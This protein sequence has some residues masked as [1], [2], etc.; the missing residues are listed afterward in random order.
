MATP[1]NCFI[2]NEYVPRQAEIRL[3]PKFECFR[4]SNEIQPVMFRSSQSKSHF[5]RFVDYFFKYVTFLP[6]NDVGTVV[7][8]T[9]IETGRVARNTRVAVAPKETVS[10][11][12]IP[13]VWRLRCV[14]F[15][16]PNSDAYLPEIYCSYLCPESSA[17]PLSPLD[18]LRSPGSTSRFQEVSYFAST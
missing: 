15:D 11:H 12:P 14:W 4:Y 17:L 16:Y 10:V 3:L 7:W 6:T 9:Y 5:I 1:C 18:G 8:S 2:D 13:I